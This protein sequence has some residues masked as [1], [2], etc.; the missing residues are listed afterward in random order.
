[1]TLP[2][3]PVS[4]FSVVTVTS[5]VPGLLG[6]VAVHEDVGLEV[7]ADRLHALRALVEAVAEQLDLGELLVG[8]RRHVEA[9]RATDAAAQRLGEGLGELRRLLLGLGVV[10][11]RLDAEDGHLLMGGHRHAAETQDAR[12][13]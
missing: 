4:M 13:E 3:V 11:L 5:Y 1:M 7:L 8:V 9:G 6:Q 12:Y 10:V 2:F